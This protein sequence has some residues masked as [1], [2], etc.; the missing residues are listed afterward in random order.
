MEGY[1]DVLVDFVVALKYEDLPHGVIEQT[2]LFIADYYAASI[3]GYRVNKQ[4][5]RVAMS[6]IKEEGGAEQA[7]ILFEKKK[8]PVGNAAFM[9]AAYAHGADMDDGNRK[10][11]GHIGTHVISSVFALGE[12]LGV[13]WKDI[14]VAINVGYEF[15]NRIAGAAQPGLYNK[16]FHSTGIAGAMACGAA[17]AK[18]MR[19]DR[20][21][22]YNSVSLSA[23]Q[24]SGLIII[25][26]S[27]QNCKPINPANAARI[28][29]LSALMAE[30]GLLSSRN[31]LESKKGWFHA[32]TD[33]VDETILLRGLGVDFTIGESYLKLYPT[34]RHTH[35]CIDGVL[36]IRE[37]MNDKN[38]FLPNIIEKIEVYIY[39]SAIKSAGIIRNPRSQEEAK[40]SIYYAIAVA[41]NN[42]DF[43][44]E[45]L[46][47]EKA[48]PVINNLLAKI[49]LVPDPLM[50]DRAC[51]IRG[52]RIKVVLC[53]GEILEE[54]IL[55]PKGEGI[56]A[57]DWNDLQIK[58]HACSYGIVSEE[59]SKRVIN[60]CMNIDANET[61]GSVMSFFDKDLRLLGYKDQHDC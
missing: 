2:K 46:Q 35:C 19:L 33:H 18:L 5:N 55:I 45:D 61:F 10:S 4:F 26:E 38:T 20:C 25:D 41:F 48:D 13:T 8:Y 29:I 59:I 14:I 50:E 24:S 27:G 32:F 37:R 11:A 40:F 7:S 17:C 39:P 43:S 6:I 47:V 3:A 12:K 56:G 1:T 21:G 51:G 58:M 23:I 15:F 9:N 22:V 60:R 16:G 34:C 49:E 36:K 42:G 30:K 53:D 44:I 57:L 31:P 54:T 28:G 52:A